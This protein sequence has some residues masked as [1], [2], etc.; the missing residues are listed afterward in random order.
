MGELLQRP[1]RL[2]PHLAR[3][4]GASATGSVPVTGLLQSV[5]WSE[6]TCMSFLLWMDQ[7]DHNDEVWAPAR[8]ALEQP[9]P[10]SINKCISGL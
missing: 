3:P 5:S 1:V 8:P 10:V 2:S 6:Q 9:A 4:W 7:W